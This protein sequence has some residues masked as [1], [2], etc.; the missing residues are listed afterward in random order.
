[1]YNVNRSEQLCQG[2][3]FYSAADLCGAHL[4]GGGL[5]CDSAGVYDAGVDIDDLPH[6]K[7]WLKR[8]ADR[9]AVSKGLD[10]P[11]ENFV[12]AQLR[13]PKKKEEL[14]EQSKKF[15]TTDK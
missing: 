6:L 3:L 2:I 11:E 7:A 10:V 14:V 5:T 8:I 13:D 1:M 15:V 9:P 12:K 4:K